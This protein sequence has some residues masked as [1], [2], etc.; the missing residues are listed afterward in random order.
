M[1]GHL[2]VE[3]CGL[4]TSV[5][6]LG[7]CGYQAFGV[8]VSGALDPVSVRIANALVGN[9][10][11]TGALEFRMMGPKLRVAADSIRV[12][13]AGTTAP[14]DILRPVRMSV[15]AGRSVRL[16]HDQIFQIRTVPDSA[17]CY[18][19]VEGGFKLPLVFGSQ[20][21]YARG[22]FGGFKGRY[23]RAGDRLPLSYAKASNSPD[24]EI[25]DN[26]VPENNGAIRVV[27]GPQADHFTANGINTL[28][29]GKFMVSPDADRMGI[30]L[31]G[32][33]IEHAG[34][35]N[36]TSDGIVNGSI[37]IPGS[38]QPIVL[39]ADR[40][41]TGGYP[42]IGTVISSDLR[43]LGRLRPGMAIYFD[44]VAVDQAEQIHRDQAVRVRRQIESISVLPEEN[45]SPEH[46]LRTENLISGFIVPS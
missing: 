18:L 38:G 3:S 13:L 24:R 12:A 45:D 6:D 7:R 26:L 29:T 28:L 17:C 46:R 33:I 41:T 23:I 20:S 34:D 22:G 25:S 42:K 37:Q 35:Y 9:P 44:S 1:S 10:E 32:P 11:D 16:Q 15:P 39:L 8:P 5:Q 30:R 19:A 27:L 40:Q 43:R 14:I 36:I 4:A 21:T 31:D 2:V